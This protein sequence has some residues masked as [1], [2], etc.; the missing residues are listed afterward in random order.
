[1]STHY[2]AYNTPSENPNAEYTYLKGTGVNSTHWT[3]TVRCRGC[4]QWSDSDSN[5]VS[6]MSTSTT[7]FSMARGFAPVLEPANN[8]SIFN[9]HDDT[10]KWE[11]D[12]TLA[13]S[14]SFNAWIA[15][16]TL[17]TSSG[18]V[19]PVNTLASN[20]FPMQETK[21]PAT[22][23]CTK[24]KIRSPRQTAT[25]PSSCS[26][27]TP[28]YA[29]SIASG[30]RATKIKGSLRTPR[31]IVIDSAGHLLVVEVGLG[32]S[33]HT[34]DASGCI[35]SSKT[36][37]SQTNL[38]H[39][40]YLSPDGLTLYASSITTVWKWTYNPT[41][42]TI[43][44]SST[45]L[46]TGMSNGGHATRTLTIPKNNPNLL[47]VSCGSN[48]NL[49]I[50]ATDMATARAVVKVFDLN[51]VPNG[52]YNYVSGGWQAG[53]GLRNEVGIVFDGNN[54]YDPLSPTKIQAS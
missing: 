51:S 24:T 18:G 34:L 27:L 41:D 38:N 17:P 31:G 4:S 2:S 19:I 20:Q 46:V 13:R 35:A 25:I 12:L 49:D 15:Q 11:H 42:A 37:I 9:V 7:T 21:P 5:L 14:P 6:F 54:M 53:Y 3:L 29:S 22:T 47:V 40:I 26:G 33:A 44:G 43:S 8:A 10:E 16:N 28:R 45:V 39:G 52:G 36:L 32:I 48:G 30:W 1:M 50:P 23:L